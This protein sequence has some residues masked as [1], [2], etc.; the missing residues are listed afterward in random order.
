[1]RLPHVWEN[2]VSLIPPLQEANRLGHTIANR[3]QTLGGGV[4]CTLCGA[5]DDPGDI[6][7]STQCPASLPPEKAPVEASDK[8]AYDRQRLWEALGC[9]VV[10]DHMSAADYDRSYGGRTW[11]VSKAVM[12]QVMQVRKLLFCPSC[13]EEAPHGAMRATPLCI[14][15]EDDVMTVFAAMGHAVCHHC[16]FEEFYPLRKDPRKREFE[17]QAEMEKMR[18]N[19]ANMARQQFPN[20]M[21]GQQQAMGMGTLLQQ[22]NPIGPMLPSEY[23]SMQN[24]YQ[25]AAKAPAPVGSTL[26]KIK[27]REDAIRLLAAAPPEKRAELMKKIL[28]S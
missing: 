13:M 10:A 5:T 14:T 28:G 2:P 1:M 9:P 23:R 18:M 7:L 25:Q 4:V 16:A 26:E 12:R 22:G 6:R 24:I 19:Q 3:V 15:V 11:C 8:A 21:L 27:T 17:E 20:G